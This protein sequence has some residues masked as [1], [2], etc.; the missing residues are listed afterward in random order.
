MDKK[1]L[2]EQFALL[3]EADLNVLLQSAQVAY[4]AATHSENKAEDQYDTRGLEASY[5]AEAQGK[6]SSQLNADLHLFRTIELKK[7]TKKTPIQAT[8][9][10]TVDCEGKETTYLLMPCA[11]GL[12]TEYKGQ[13]IQVITPQSPIGAALLGKQVDD[14]I[15]ILVQNKSKD[16]DIVSVG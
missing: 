2:I 3:M 16:F 10:V 15:T 13:R 12:T 5:L 9:L 14:Q 7:F 4:E 8:A 1:I 6:R 11:G